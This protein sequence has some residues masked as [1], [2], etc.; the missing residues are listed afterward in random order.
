M[1][2]AGAT[3]NRWEKHQ[4]RTT[5]AT[6]FFNRSLANTLLRECDEAFVGDVRSFRPQTLIALDEIFVTAGASTFLALQ[7][8][9]KHSDVHDSNMAVALP[10]R[11]DLADLCSWVDPR[12]IQFHAER[13]E[14]VRE[15]IFMATEDD[16]DESLRTIL[17]RSGVET[18]F[19]K[20]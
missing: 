1:R 7:E 13:C 4:D 10:K 3:C 5:S 15:G 6:Y 16:D 11:L 20:V 8:L 19:E 17:D 2:T 12:I 9:V 18:L 14:L